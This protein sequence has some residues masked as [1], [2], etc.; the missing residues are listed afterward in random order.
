MTYTPTPWKS[1]GDDLQ[2]LL[3]EIT[4]TDCG[5]LSVILREAIRTIQPCPFDSQNRN[6]EAKNAVYTTASKALFVSHCVSNWGIDAND[7][8]LIESCWDFVDYQLNSSNICKGNTNSFKQEGFQIGSPWHGDILQA[9]ILFLSSNPGITY[10]CLFPRW[11]PCGGFFTMGGTDD[12]GNEIYD[13]T[14][15]DKVK[16]TQTVK[17]QV[18]GAEEIYEFLRDRLSETTYVN[19]DSGYTDAWVIG[20]GNIC[21]NKGGV[22]YWQALRRIMN[23]LL[24][25]VDAITPQYRIKHTQRLMRSVLSIEIIPFGSQKEHGVSDDVIDFYFSKYTV[26]MLKNCGARI[27]F[28][29]GKAVRK[30]FNRAAKKISPSVAKFENGKF[31]PDTVLSLEGHRRVFQVAVIDGPN[32]HGILN[33]KQVCDDLKGEMGKNVFLNKALKKAIY[34]YSL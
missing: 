30:C 28:L 1:L 3:R 19:P 27:I 9:P 11:H 32:A 10:R 15:T 21:K 23:N 17:N 22:Q 33:H 16:N 18:A 14:C 29:V 2:R 31:Y 13:I 6:T 20:A 34:L 5:K 8:P 24:G 12:T 26:P 25:F 7:K 4:C